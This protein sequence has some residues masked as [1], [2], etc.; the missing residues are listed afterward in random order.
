MSVDLSGMSRKELQALQARIDK[1][2]LRLDRAKMKKA[3]AAAEKAARA[4]VN[5]A[6]RLTL[7]SSKIKMLITAT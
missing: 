5:G 1:A 7:R 4:V 3:V 6:S 2:L